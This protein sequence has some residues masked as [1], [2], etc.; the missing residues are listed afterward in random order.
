[1]VSSDTIDVS[2]FDIASV[3]VSGPRRKCAGAL[4]T[5]LVNY[6]G[7]AQYTWTVTGGDIVSGGDGPSAD[8]QWNSVDTGKIY[9][10]MTAGSCNGTIATAVLLDPNIAPKRNIAADT[11]LCEGDSLTIEAQS[12]YTVYAWSNGASGRSITVSTTGYYFV[13]ATNTAGCISRSDTVYVLFSQNPLKPSIVQSHGLL[14]CTTQAQRYQWYENGQTIPGATDDTLVY[15]G[16]GAH[17]VQVWNEYGCTNISDPLTPVGGGQPG[18]PGSFTVDIMPNPGNG[19]F[20]VAIDF[21]TPR[22][23][24]IEVANSAGMKVA[25]YSIH[26]PAMSVRK[27]ISLGSAA[28]GIY[29]LKVQAGSDVRWKKVIVQHR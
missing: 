2:V 1:M 19:V 29:L 22:A 28:P 15:T 16:T 20:V 11:V 12:G 21:P 5:Y 18:L 23:C 4:G 8:I 27:Q 17:T 10:E 25:S 13:E 14:I 26:E 6:P 9:I 7:P 3:T 24:T